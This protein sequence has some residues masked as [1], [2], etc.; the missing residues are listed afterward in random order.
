MRATS[1]NACRYDTNAGTETD[2]SPVACASV[3]QGKLGYL[4]DV[5]AERESGDVI[6]A[7]CGL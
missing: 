7:M 4:G 2:E 6:L 5:N 3:G 1:S